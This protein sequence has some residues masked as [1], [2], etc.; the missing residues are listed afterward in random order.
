[1]RH[2]GPPT[3][4]RRRRPAA[5]QRWCRTA[6]LGWGSPVRLDP[7]DVHAHRA[8]AAVRAGPRRDPGVA[9]SPTRG[10][11]GPGQRLPPRPSDLGPAVRLAGP[12]PRL[13][14]GLV[15]RHLPAAVRLPGRLHR[16]PGRRLRPRPAGTAAPHAAEPGPTARLR[17]R[18]GRQRP[19]GARAGRRDAAPAALPGR[20]PRRLGRRRARLPAGGRQPRLPHQ[21]VVRP[22]GR[23]RGQPLRLPRQ[24][25]GH[26]RPGLR[27]QP[28]PVRRPAGGG[29]VLRVRPEAVQRR[30][31]PLRRRLRNRSRAARCRPAVPGRGGGHRRPRPAAAPRDPRGQPPAED[32][33]HLRAPDRA[34]LRARGDGPRRGRERRLLRPGGLPPAG[35][36]VHLG[37]GHQ[38]TGRQAGTAGVRRLLPADRGHQRRCRAHLRV[39][40]RLQPGPVR[41]RLVRP[42]EGGD[43]QARERLLPRRHRDDGDEGRRRRSVPGRTAAGRHCRA[44][45][46]SRLHHHG[47]L[48][49]VGEAAGGQLPGRADL[50]GGDR[51][52]GARAV[53][54]TV[55]PAATGLAAPGRGRRRRRYRRGRWARPRRRPRWPHRGRGRP[56][57]HL[58]QPGSRARRRIPGA[59]ARRTLSGSTL[60]QER[61]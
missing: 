10:L 52:G 24:Q 41:E 61:V 17:P 15:L 23:G 18:R 28:H 7:A 49:A 31:R 45:R 3:R 58:V 53:P 56:G 22:A 14:L 36:P 30:R 2:A 12:V 55:R 54:V 32:R 11:P 4:H 9:H 1:D 39:P 46:W 20:R 33:R 25:R 42:A 38:G 21:P 59:L 26:R 43:R 29:V 6:R 47:R 34:R 16:A 57:R 27:Q 5:R 8:G 50:A 13:H 37:R 60:P 35:R 48:P 40:R 51:L 19:R 44:A